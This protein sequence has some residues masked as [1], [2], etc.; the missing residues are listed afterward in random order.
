MWTGVLGSGGGV[1]GVKVEENA[2][3][4]WNTLSDDICICFHYI[5]CEP[6][7]I[8]S[9]AAVKLWLG[10]DCVGHPPALV[11]PVHDLKLFP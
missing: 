5:C 11:V 10:V 6:T 9:Q 3:K 7:G 1:E 2:W 4:G 8:P